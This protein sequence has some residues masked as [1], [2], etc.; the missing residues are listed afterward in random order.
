MKVCLN[1]IVKNETHVLRRCLESVKPLIKSWVI[2]DTGSTDGTQAL[3]KQIL[4]DIPGE[5][6]ERPWVDFG[7]N[8]TEALRLAEAHGDYLLFIDADEVFTYPEDFK[9]SEL[10]ADSYDLPVEYSGTNYYRT[11]LISTKLHWNWNGVLHE[12]LTSS[13]PASKNSLSYPKIFVRHDGARSKNKDTYKN[14]AAVLR[15]ALDKDPN[16]ARYAFY[17]AQS[18]RDAG[19]IKAAYNAYLHR[20]GMPGWVEETWYAKY[21]TARMLQFMGGEPVQ[22]YLEAYQY[23]PTRAEPL[24][25]LV[26][27]HRIKK[28]MHLAHMYAKHALTIPYPSD[29]LFVNTEIYRW[30]IQD[31]FAI[32]AYYVGDFEAG[33]KVCQQLLEGNAPV[34]ERPRIEQN[35]QHYIKLRQ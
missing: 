4:K 32:V 19:D 21:E 14:D 3:I 2:T 9:W 33:R 34:E 27:H 23:R 26:R 7:T 17:L 13:T 8:R 31:E 25:Q 15:E 28:E 22:A 10:T 18:L 6:H 11:A 5:L 20:A 24:Y 30:R 35:L 16:N 12:Y 1:M 29:R